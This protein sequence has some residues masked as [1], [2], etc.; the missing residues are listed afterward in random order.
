VIAVLDFGMGNIHSCL[1]A[2]SL[3]SKD[4][5]YT[6][7]IRMI[8]RAEKLVLPG[9]G[10]FKKAMS[11]LVERG[12]VQSIENH[13]S[14]GKP[15]LGICIGYQVLFQDSDEHQSHP[16]DLIKGLSLVDGQIRR[17][18]DKK[19]VKVPHMGWNQLKN[20][21][22]KKTRILSGIAEGSFMYF[23]HSYRPIGVKREDVSAFCN[24]YGE[25]FPAVIE[26]NNI[27]GTQFHPEKSDK[28]G[29]K[30]LE[31]FIKV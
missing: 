22:K 26:K 14:Q 25:S 19:N 7:D 24:Y 13:V 17:F 2:L 29:L 8:E 6:N 10:A 16:G 20:I 9:D 21:T 23:I 18:K 12:L 11:N 31:N 4:V 1:K 30:I 28:L 15:I 3:Y 5:V 27:F